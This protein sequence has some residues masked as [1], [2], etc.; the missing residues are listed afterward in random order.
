MTEELETLQA[1]RDSVDTLS[2]KIGELER[3]TAERNTK[4]SHRIWVAIAGVM[5]LVIAVLLGAVAL[6]Y[7]VKEAHCNRTFN[8]ATA[9]RTGIISPATLDLNIS[10]GRVVKTLRP[11]A[12]Q[13]QAETEAAFNQALTAYYD[14]FDQYVSD[15]ASN[16]APVAPKYA[17]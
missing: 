5:V 11:P 13:T 2:G 12:G 10:L 6:G 17:C 3:T 7:S 14:K 15:Y 4:L 16:P 1:V 8:N 9:Q